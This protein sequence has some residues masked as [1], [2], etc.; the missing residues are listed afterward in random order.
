MTRAPEADAW[1]T[2]NP[3]GHIRI[4][5]IGTPPSRCPPAASNAARDRG[6]SAAYAA[7]LPLDQPREP[8]PVN[9]HRVPRLPP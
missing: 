7:P 2:G 5:V 4:H 9:A 3:P 6:K 1:Y 8:L